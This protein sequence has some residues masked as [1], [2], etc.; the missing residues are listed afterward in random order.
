MVDR[1]NFTDGLGAQLM[2]RIHLVDLALRSGCSYV[3]TPLRA[4]G[5]IRTSTAARIEALFRLDQ[6]VG[7]GVACDAD[8]WQGRTWAEAVDDV[9]E[10]GRK[11][12]GRAR[13]FDSRHMHYLYVGAVDAAPPSLQ[14]AE[15]L[16]ASLRARLQAIAAPWYMRSMPLAPSNIARR[17]CR[18][19]IAVHVR[20]GDL[21][22]ALTSCKRPEA[23]LHPKAP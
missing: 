8:S 5:A 23:E 20:Y 3:H 10:G 15:R 2:R 7:G 22:T 18:I 19:D 4:G 9:R 6:V 1:R 13:R 14:S 11:H 16:R 21:A 12:A 17:R